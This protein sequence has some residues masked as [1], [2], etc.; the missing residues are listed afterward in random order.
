VKRTQAGEIAASPFQSNKIADNL[1][2]TGG[3]KYLRYGIVR[4][5]GLRNGFGLCKITKKKG[6]VEGFIAM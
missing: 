3:I 4:D 1:F 2:H 6:V 5:Q